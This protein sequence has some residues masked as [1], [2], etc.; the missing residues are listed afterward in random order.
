MDHLKIKPYESKYYDDVLALFKQNCP[1][2]F[3]PTEEQDFINYLNNEIEAYYVLCSQNDE[4]VACG[5]IN[6]FEDK[7][8]ARLSWDMVSSAHQNKKIGAFL[9]KE[10]LK[11]IPEKYTIVV[12]TSQLVFEFY[13]KM[14]FDVHSIQKDYWAKGFDLYLMK[15]KK[16]QL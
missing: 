3:D 13:Q 6:F 15:L 5:G 7:L 16:Q 10:R 4:I 1:K 14:G 8:E 2:Y 12:R 9:V 11:R